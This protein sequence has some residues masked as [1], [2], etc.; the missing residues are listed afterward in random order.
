MQGKPRRPDLPCLCSKLAEFQKPVGGARNHGSHQPPNNR[1]TPN[2][3]AGD[4]DRLF[5]AMADLRS[6][7]SLLLSQFPPPFT[8][9]LGSHRYQTSSIVMCSL[10]TCHGQPPFSA[11]NYDPIPGPWPQPTPKNPESR[12]PFLRSRHWP[13]AV[14]YKVSAILQTALAKISCHNRQAPVGTAS[15]SADWH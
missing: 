14:F 12:Q 13:G 8:R 10:L 5:L 1:S 4:R 2:Q 15:L 7:L 3:T 9:F 11:G 6:H